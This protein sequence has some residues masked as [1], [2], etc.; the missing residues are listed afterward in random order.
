[1]ILDN[2]AFCVVAYDDRVQSTSMIFSSV[3]SASQCR[4]FRYCEATVDIRSVH[5]GTALVDDACGAV[6]SHA[7][8]H[9]SICNDDYASSSKAEDLSQPERCC[10]TSCRAIF[11][12]STR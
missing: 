8:F 12:T 5:T 2:D 4:G 10:Q 6:R 11:C 7:L 1:M 3:E 9:K